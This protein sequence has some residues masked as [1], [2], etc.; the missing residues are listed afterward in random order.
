M[1]TNAKPKAIL[2]AAGNC[3]RDCPDNRCAFG[4][5]PPIGGAN[6]HPAVLCVAGCDLNSKR[7][8]YS[9]QG[10]GRLTAKKPDVTTFTHF[11]G[12]QVFAPDPDSGTSAACPVAAGVIAAIRSK[13]PS[14]QLSP[15]QLRALIG[16]TAADSGGKGFDSDF[17]YGVLDVA[18]LRA[19][20]L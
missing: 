2:F 8:G 17:G 16:K 15:M 11:T 4:N 10:P 3:G 9:S 12:S 13:H 1:C 20:L 18:A 14:T 7:V 6:S 5:A 19:A